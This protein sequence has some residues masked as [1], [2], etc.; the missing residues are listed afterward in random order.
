MHHIQSNR[1]TAKE[2]SRYFR[3]E[4]FSFSGCCCFCY[5]GRRCSYAAVHGA[6]LFSTSCLGCFFYLSA[7]TV[8]HFPHNVVTIAACARSTHSTLCNDHTIQHFQNI[9]TTSNAG[10]ASNTFTASTTLMQSHEQHGAT[11]SSAYTLTLRSASAIR[12]YISILFIHIA[13]SHHT[14][15][16]RRHLRIRKHSWLALSHIT[17][18]ALH[19]HNFVVLHHNH[20]IFQVHRVHSNLSIKQCTFQTTTSF[21]TSDLTSLTQASCVPLDAFAAGQQRSQLLCSW[22][23][24]ALGPYSGPKTHVELRALGSYLPRLWVPSPTLLPTPTLIQPPR[25]TPYPLQH[26]SPTRHGQ[27]LS[28]QCREH[29]YTRITATTDF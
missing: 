11:G 5:S 2:N 4:M 13:S 26:C 24:A 20:N 19:Y 9:F 23:H 17:Y 7:R 27:A 6:V 12:R 29:E 10:I 18:V 8:M 15:T 21:F 3:S 16:L 22:S 1:L 25:L 14:S 28:P